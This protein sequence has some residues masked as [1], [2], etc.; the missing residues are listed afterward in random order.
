MKLNVRYYFR[1]RTGWHEEEIDAT[2]LDSAKAAV[3]TKALQ[4]INQGYW[5]DH[6][7]GSAMWEPPMPLS[8][9]MVRPVKDKDDAA[10]S[11]SAPVK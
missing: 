5:A 7:D 6:Q 3:G 9:V 1:G 11:K 2:D 10:E 4:I 8:Y